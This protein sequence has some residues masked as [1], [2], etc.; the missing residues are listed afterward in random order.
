MKMSSPKEISRMT[1]EYAEKLAESG[2]FV[3]SHDTRYGENLYASPGWGQGMRKGS[4]AKTLGIRSVNDW[5]N[6]IADYN[7]AN[8]QFQNGAIKT[9]HFT[10]VIWKVGRKTIEGETFRSAVALAWELPDARKA[11]T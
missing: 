10:Q 3:H 7:F 5:Y 1:Q 11:N 8:P 9:R 2:E 4:D 6:E